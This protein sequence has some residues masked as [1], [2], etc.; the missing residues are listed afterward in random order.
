MNGLSSVVAS[1]I[2][3][4]FVS[5][6][7]G[8]APTHAEAAALPVP[9]GSTVAG[10]RPSYISYPGITVLSSLPRA[11][12]KVFLTVDDGITRLPSTAKIL[13]STPAM[14]FPVGGLVRKDSAYFRVLG[15]A[16]RAIEDH[17]ASHL[18]L[19][20]LSYAVQKEQICRGRDQVA[21]AVGA[22]PTVLRPPYGSYDLTTLK[23]AV[24]CGMKY[25]LL[26]DVTV[27]AGSLQTWG[28]RITSG[29]VVLMHF[30]PS[31]ASDFRLLRARVA[32]QHLEFA[33]LADYLT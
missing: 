33:D 10:A 13:R 4:S 32:A 21:Q 30:T 23:A 27:H 1:V 12:G 29:D 15:R 11:R 7:L 26:W 9:A 28:G 18:R 2:A 17:T 24:A 20:G 6:G 3:A 16:G 22:A 14:I 8:V 19:Q 31:F 5:L 25:L